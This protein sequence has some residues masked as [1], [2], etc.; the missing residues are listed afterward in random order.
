VLYSLD[1]TRNVGPPPASV[2]QGRLQRFRAHEYLLRSGESSSRLHVVLDGWAARYKLLPDGRRQITA[3]YVRGD[4][5]DPSWLSPAAVPQPVVAM[6]GLKTA[7]VSTREVHDGAEQDSRLMS[8]VWDETRVALDTQSEWALNLGRKSARER[9]AHLFCE[10]A[11]RLGAI[12]SGRGVFCD[13]PLTQ[14]EIADF[15]GLTSVHVNRTIKGLRKD[16]LIELRGHRLHIPDVAKLAQIGL[17]AGDYLRMQR[18][19][20]GDFI[21]LQAH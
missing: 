8:A 3:L 18:A 19:R 4:L 13:M 15:T 11:A 10:L 2:L 16:R 21:E 12:G 7:S 5:C 1:V 9:L 20:V 17:F 14:N 6:S